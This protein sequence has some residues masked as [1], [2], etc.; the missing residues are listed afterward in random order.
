MSRKWV[1]ESYT[2]GPLYFEYL[3]NAARISDKIF[4]FYMVDHKEQ[5]YIDVG[6]VDETVMKGGI[7]NLVY[8]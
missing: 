3:Y 5:S 7:D 6:F 2:T 1:S 4:C 8:I